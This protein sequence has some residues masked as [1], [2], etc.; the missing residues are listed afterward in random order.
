MVALTAFLLHCQGKD[1]YTAFY[2]CSRTKDDSCVCK[3]TRSDHIN[4]DGSGSCCVV[5]SRPNRQLVAPEPTSTTGCPFLAKPFA[6]LASVPSILCPHPSCIS[7]RR[8]P[9][10][11]C[12][13][14]ASLT[15]QPGLDSVIRFAAAELGLALLLLASAHRAVCWDQIERLAALV[16]HRLLA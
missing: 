7:G 9:E 4:R 10:V 11:S 12:P 3:R 13:L 1:S 8:D 14:L 15:K 5:S 16:R 2:G 6:A